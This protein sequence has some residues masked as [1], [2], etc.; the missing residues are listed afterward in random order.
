MATEMFSLLYVDDEPALLDISRIFLERTGQFTVDTATSGPE[1]LTLLGSKTYD[2]IISDYQMPGMDG[3][4]FLK[5]VRS[6]GNTLPFIVFTGRGREEVAILALNEGADFYLQKGGDPTVQFAEL[7]NKVRYAI[8]RRRAEVALKQ[9]EA[10]LRQIIDLVPHRIF[11]KDRDGTYLLVNRAVAEGYNTTVAGITGKPQ[12][13]FHKDPAEL[14]RMI[15]DDREVMDTGKVKFIP[16]EPFTD[17]FG[18]RRFHQ[19]TKVPFT[20]LGNN[21]QAVLGVAIDITERKRIEEELRQK[22]EA[23]SAVNEQITAADGELRSTL[24]SKARQERALRESEER[25]RN[26]VEDQTEFISRF[27]PDGT[28]VFVNEAYCRYFGLERSELLGH[29]FKP[30]IPAG[31]RERV[32]RFFLSLT[33]DHPA[34]TI[35]HRIVMPDGSIRWQR[36]S[37]R[38]IF[39]PSGTLAEYQSVGRDI[40]EQKAAEA[41]LLESGKKYRSTLDALTDAVSVVDQ[42]FTLVLA[43]RSLTGWLRALGQGEDIIGKPFLEAFPFLPPSVLDEYREVFR[44]GTAMVSEESTQIGGAVIVTETRKIPLAED[45]KVVAVIAIIRDITERREA[46]RALRESEEKYRSLYRNATLGIFH[47]T[48]GGRFTDVNPA[49]ATLLGY[50]SPEEAVSSIASIARQVY[51]D[52]PRYGE[53]ASA[54]LESGGVFSTENAYRRRDGT[55]W[56]GRLHIRGIPGEGGRPVSYEGFVEDI[57]GLRQAEEALRESEEKFRGVFAAESDGIALIDRKTGTIT[58]CNE[59]FLLMHGYR[60]DEAIGLPMMALSGDPDATRAALSA[61]TRSIRDRFHRRKDGSVFPVEITVSGMTLQGRDILI[62]AIRD[63]SEK[64]LAEQEFQ[65]SEEKFRMVFDT[66]QSALIILEMDADGM[67]AEIIDANRTAWAQLGY[68]REE[69]MHKTYFSLDA[70]EYHR[71][72]A[73]HIAGLSARNYGSYESVRVRKDG[74]RFPVEVKVHR[75]MMGG[76]EVIVS[77]ARDISTRKKTE[78]TLRRANR[79]LSLLTGITRHDIGNQVTA[80]QNYLALVEADPSGPSREKYLREAGT[81]ARRI[82]SVIQFTRE[83]ESVGVNAP[84]WL[85]CRALVETAA[86]QAPLGDVRVSNGMPAGTEVFADPLIVKV[87]YNLIENAVRYGGKITAIRFSAEKS[88][89]DL[90]LSCEDDGGGVPAGDKKRIFG[91]GFGKHTGLGL[92][93]SREILDITG[94]GIRENGEPGRG[95]RFEMTVPEGAWREC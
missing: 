19:T 11:A 22:N 56:Y 90:V 36:W 28:H 1:A 41:A 25:Y 29:R 48:P 75:M 73:R 33:P 27:L 58:D 26:V 45:G 60:K 83:Y 94:I 42:D 64:R 79:K 63:V 54:V 69:L 35:E 2:A 23:L 66:A 8:M 39:S 13:L 87:F 47:S 65:K 30:A 14:R 44:T 37:D 21:R 59:A 12:S 10:Q 80:L 76:R 52:P 17:G 15:A 4:E 43:N 40:T 57:T 46:E 86:Q 71:A 3:I 95:A 92:A 6:A 18:N 32:R 34:G 49:L 61:G 20:T 62:G 91:R 55:R 31:D 70:R 74:G 78:E 5:R 77:S 50:A 16:E 67:P 38:A 7:S 24:E 85:D 84:V 81:A 53:V 51:F 88:G 9:E 72:I 82:S 89:R 68:T 93:L